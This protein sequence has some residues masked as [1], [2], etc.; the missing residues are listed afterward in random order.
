[1][2]LHTWIQCTHN[3]YMHWETKKFVWLALLY[4]LLWCGT[5]PAVSLRYACI[6][7]RCTM[8]KDFIRGECPCKGAGGD[9]VIRLLCRSDTEWKRRKKGWVKSK[10]VSSKAFREPYT[11]SPVLESCISKD[12][13]DLVYL[14][15]SVIGQ[16]WPMGN[17]TSGKCN[18][19]FQSTAAGALDQLSSP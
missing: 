12:R 4:T 17:V 3:C 2:P 10:E 6:I 19:G 15:H 9:L 8:C 14:P 11:Q 16:E 18:D 7:L 13:P 1:M 5:K